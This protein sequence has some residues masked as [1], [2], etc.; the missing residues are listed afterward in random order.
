[1][2]VD[3]KAVKFDE[4]KPQID[5]LLE[6]EKDFDITFYTLTDEVEKVVEYTINQILTKYGKFELLPFLYT[7]VKE[8]MVNA[9]KANIKRLLFEEAGLDINNENDYYKG[10]IEFRDNLSEALMNEYA[11]KLKKRNKYVKVSFHYSEDGLRIEVINNE[12]L[13]PIEDKRI[14]VKLSKAMQYDDIAQFYMEQ[15][16]ELEGAGLGIALIVMLLKG[17]GV[18]PAY[19]RIGTVDGSYTRARIEI[20]FTD[21]FVSLRDLYLK[22]KQMEQNSNR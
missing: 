19:F 18:D 2:A 22:R 10:L 21:K 15:G 1:M 3:L 6:E 7:C 13:T 12:P 11:P 17:V 14:R 20:A 16:D 8:L 9:T 4:L 5:K